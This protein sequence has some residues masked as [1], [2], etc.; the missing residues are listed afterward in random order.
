M[1]KVNKNFFISYTNIYESIEPELD[2]KLD[3]EPPVF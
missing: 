2:V 1:F 3:P